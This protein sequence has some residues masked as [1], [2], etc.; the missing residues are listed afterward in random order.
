LLESR[1][2]S[3]ISFIFSLFFL[4]LGYRQLSLFRINMFITSFQGLPWCQR[5][6]HTVYVC[7]FFPPVVLSKLFIQI[8]SGLIHFSSNIPVL[9]M[10]YSSA[11]F[12]CS[13]VSHQH[14]LYFSLSPARIVHES[15]P[16]NR[17][18]S[19]AAF[20]NI[21]FRISELQST[22]L[23]RNTDHPI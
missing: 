4:T 7:A 8:L 11:A 3:P 2:Q 18:V 1:N 9:N 13:Q 23:G 19:A 16:Y 20:Y 17:V 6:F 5:F 22:N 10:I 12:N 21:A 15:L 14:W